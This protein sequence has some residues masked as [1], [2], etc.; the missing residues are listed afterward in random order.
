MT[1]AGPAVLLVADDLSGA[2][3]SAAALADREHTAV[4]L[5]A[6][7]EWPQASVVAVDTDSRYLPGPQAADRVAAVVRRSGPHTLVYKKIDSTLR[8]NIG[9]ETAACLAALRERA[10]PGEPR[11]LAVVAPAFPATGRTVVDGQVLL[12]GRPLTDAHPS[13]IPLT[14]QLRAAGLEVAHLPA[15]GADRGLAPLIGQAD[16]VIV[17]SVTDEDLAATVRACRALPVLLVGSGGLA[18]HLTG[19]PPGR[20]DAAARALPR[21]ALVCV[22]SRSDVAR[23]QCAALLEATE[24]LPVS[25]PV[26]VPVSVTDT[27]ARDAAAHR[28]ADALHAGRDVVVRPDPAEPVDPAR[29]ADMAAALAGVARAGLGA[30]G[31]LV[32]AGGETAR[33]VL[34]AAGVPHLR[35]VG[36]RE[37]GVVEMR[38]GDGLRVVTK[39][40]SFGDEKV[41]TRLLPG[42]AG[43]PPAAAAPAGHAG[44]GAP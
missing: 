26:P 12:H 20:G 11:P 14:R 42:A 30:A 17:D 41:L 19:F 28:V 44:T 31:T 21:P 7:A 2:A 40:G 29:A 38:T 5:H 35:V 33:A 25:V 4:A 8:G 22:G 36:E 9:P 3:D 34:G 23:A 39:A 16:A 27:A 15:D 32:A 10:A 43:H 37:P 6:G 18:H 13:R 1:A 24:A